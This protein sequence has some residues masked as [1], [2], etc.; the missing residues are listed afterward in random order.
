MLLHSAAKHAIARGVKEGWRGDA[1]RALPLAHRPT[2]TP[3]P[4]KAERA[5]TRPSAIDQCRDETVLS[6]VQVPCHRM[7]PH[8]RQEYQAGNIQLI[9]AC[10]PKPHNCGGELVSSVPVTCFCQYKTIR[11]PLLVWRGARKSKIKLHRIKRSQLR[12]GRQRDVCDNSGASLHANHT[13]M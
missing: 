3:A 5:E 7:E 6:S 9:R 8:F 4:S 1:K 10:D 11:V 13:A 12:Q 2:C